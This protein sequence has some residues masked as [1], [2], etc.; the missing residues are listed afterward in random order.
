M[1]W[2]ARNWL[3]LAMT[4]MIAAAAHVASVVYLPDLIMARTMAKLAG[5]GGVNTML[6]GARATDAS[7]AVVRPSPDLLYSTCVYDLDKAG[8]RLRVH[9]AGMPRTYW[10]V[11]AFDAR[12][13]NF[14]VLDDRQARSGAFD[15]T[16]A[17]PGAAAHPGDIRSPTARGII[18]VRTL[19]ESEARL[20]AIDAARRAARCEAAK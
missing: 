16:F 8:G 14:Y 17:G 20:A 18:L 7:R 12:T 1:R 4:L 19:I 6:H 10:S 15:V 9:A 11:S 13:D 2:L 3:Y 5:A